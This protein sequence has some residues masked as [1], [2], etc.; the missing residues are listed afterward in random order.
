M[1]IDIS[2]KF[3]TSLSL[4]FRF[5]QSRRDSRFLLLTINKIFI[6]LQ[7]QVI[8][9]LLQFELFIGLRFQILYDVLSV[10]RL[11]LGVRRGHAAIVELVRQVHHLVFLLL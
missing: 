3:S 10:G 4:L 7:D 8:I 1:L 11:V 9:D 5:L 6:F 2:L